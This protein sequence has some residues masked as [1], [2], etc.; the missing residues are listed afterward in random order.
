MS[1]LKKLKLNTQ[2][3]AVFFGAVLLLSLGNFFVYGWLLNKIGQEQQIVNQERLRTVQVR[4]QEALTD[5][6]NSCN[7]LFQNE[8]YRKAS[9]EDMQ[10]YMQMEMHTTASS[11]LASQYLAGYTIYVRNS[12]YVI[13]S[14]GAYDL[15]IY[16]GM[17]KAGE[18][19]PE[20]WQEC[21]DQQFF[22]RIYPASTYQ[23]RSANGQLVEKTL[24]P[25]VR[26]SQWNEDVFVVLYLDIDKVC[27][28]G[29]TVLWQGVYLFSDE[30]EYLY[31][32]DNKTLVSHINQVTEEKYS[33]YV[34]ID[35]EN[36]GRKKRFSRTPKRCTSGGC[37][38]HRR[39]LY[40]DDGA[41]DG[42]VRH[43]DL[44]GFSSFCV[45]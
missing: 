44:S 14:H 21:F 1:K 15:A 29:E 2:L 39:Q 13:T 22:S 31:T 19:D 3:L 28:Q 32:T 23:Y 41:A 40:I 7:R 11:A 34:D 20:N 16:S 10:A 9:A 24:L 38:D 18:A 8:N 4:V 27:K 33:F 37:V 30:G 43:G 5:M 42:G 12:N 25:L 17:K 6:E 35:E 36:N 26:K 45:P